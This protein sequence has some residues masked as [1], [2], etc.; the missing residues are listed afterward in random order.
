[1][2][3]WDGKR[4]YVKCGIRKWWFHTRAEADAKAEE[5]NAHGLNPRVRH[6]GVL[7]AL[8]FLLLLGLALLVCG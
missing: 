7:P 8:L 2:S 4:W 6:S 5:L 1:M 3:G